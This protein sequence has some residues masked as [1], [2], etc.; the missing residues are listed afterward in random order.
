MKRKCDECCY[1]YCGKK[2]EEYLVLLRFQAV[3]ARPSGTR[4]LDQDRVLKMKE[5]NM[6][7][8]VLLENEAQEGGSE[9]DLIL[10]FC[11]WR[12]AK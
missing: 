2:G 10:E 3:P 5:V 8:S 11:V 6:V 4:R 9:H 7:V 1:V 12:D